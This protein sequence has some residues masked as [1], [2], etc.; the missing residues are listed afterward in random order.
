MTPWAAALQASLS[1]TISQS[2]LR[3]M[4]IESVIL[5]WFDL[6]LVVATPPRI[7]VSVLQLLLLLFEHLSFLLFLLSS[8]LSSL[9]GIRAFPCVSPGRNQSDS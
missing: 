8:L 2:L 1:L 3:L 6:A 5:F 7:L 9:V 4:S